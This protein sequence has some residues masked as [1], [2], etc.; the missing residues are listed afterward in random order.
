MTLGLALLRA[1]K[2]HGAQEIF[3]IPGDFILPLFKQI[4]ESRILPLHT[5]SHEP[6]LGFAADAA[7]RMHC[8]LGVMAVTY[9]AGALNVVNAV[10][11][12][13]AECSPLVILAGCPGEVEAHSG[14]VLHHQVRSIDSQ[15]RIF[16]EITCD[17]VRLS[18]ADTAPEDIARVLRNCREYSQ[19][20]LIEI[21][22]DMTLQPMREVPVLPPRSFNA[23]AVAEAADEWLARI[24]AAKNPVMV[25]DVEVRRF[26][27]EA[28]VAEL[29]RRLQLPV[30]TTFMG[31]GLLAEDGVDLHGTYL[32]VAGAPETTARRKFLAF[33]ATS[34][35]RCSSRS[36]KAASC[37]CTP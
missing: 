10:A 7:A 36:K 28:R 13:Y 6:A 33:P 30:L 20:V 35:C 29:A 24:H 1:L 34:S 5:L 27:V 19:P 32:G 2:N 18:N 37:R 31:R 15:L 22:R 8:G 3:G 17:Q 26:G 21:P 4:E 11:S 9:G 25:V 23:E 14:L 12:A 16:S